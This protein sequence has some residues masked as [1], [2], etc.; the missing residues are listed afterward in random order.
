MRPVTF[1]SLFCAALALTGCHEKQ[2]QPTANS[3]AHAAGHSPTDH[4]PADHSPEPV[5]PE[6]ASVQA[7]LALHDFQWRLAQVLDGQQQDVTQVPTDLLDSERGIQLRFID[8]RLL[9]EGLC[10][11]L[12]AAYQQQGDRLSLSHP[13]STMKACP[14]SA[15]MAAEHYLAAQLPRLN[16]YHFDGNH[17]QLHL[18]FDDQTQ[19][20]LRGERTLESRYGEPE[21]L[22]YE[23]DAALRPCQHP[24]MADQRC[25]Y[26]RQVHYNEQGI[27]TGEDAWALFSSPIEG[28]Q[29]SED[30]HTI[31]RLKR[32]TVAEPAADQAGYRYVLDMVVSRSLAR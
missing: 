1:A 22:F 21:V 2:A 7:N 13:V 23:I 8:Q 14:D 31:I 5:A 18:Q 17:Q 28:Y 16:H 4:H 12:S 15:L 30:S 25:Y 10:N 32:Y 19:W 3:P 26:A 20:Q 9:I 24:L 29:H 6:P 11:H 27:K